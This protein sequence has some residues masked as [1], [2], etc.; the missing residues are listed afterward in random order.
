LQNESREEKFAAQLRNNCQ[1][2][3]EQKFHSCGTKSPYDA[4][5]TGEWHIDAGLQIEVYT[6][7][8]GTLKE[9]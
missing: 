5:G 8:Q 3:A 7:T 1:S 4:T 6:D 9:E 2:A